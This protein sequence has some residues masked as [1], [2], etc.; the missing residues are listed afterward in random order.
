MWFYNTKIGG[1]YNDAIHHPL[2]P[3]D[4]LVAVPDDTYA[5][6]IAGQS[7]G[8]LI[9]LI[10]GQPTLTDPEPLSGDALIASNM[11]LQAARSAAAA[12]A[13]APLQ[14]A[15]DLGVITDDEQDRLNAWK[16]YRVDLMRAD[17]TSNPVAWP[18]SPT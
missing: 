18:P 4:D 3:A 1:F 11:R 7:A 12:T 14:D 8:K 16:A 5:A 15:Q 9:A 10:N 17:L 6:L 13:M 2:P